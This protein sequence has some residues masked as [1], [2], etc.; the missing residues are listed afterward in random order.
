MIKKTILA[1]VGALLFSSLGVVHPIPTARAIADHPLRLT[2]LCRDSKGRFASCGI[3]DVVPKLR[4]PSISINLGRVIPSVSVGSPVRWGFK[5]PFS[6]TPRIR[7]MKFQVYFNPDFDFFDTNAKWV[8]LAAFKAISGQAQVTSQ[9]RAGSQEYRVYG[10]EGGGYA[11]WTSPTTAKKTKG[12]PTT[13]TFEVTPNPVYVD[14]EATFTVRLSDT[15]TTRRVYF[16]T[17]S[18]C[19]GTSPWIAGKGL[20]EG[21]SVLGESS[22]ESDV[23]ESDA[24]SS[25][26]YMTTISKYDFSEWVASKSFPI[27]TWESVKPVT[28]Q[29]SKGL[30]SFAMRSSL[31]DSGRCLAAVA[32]AVGNREM[33]VSSPVSLKVIPQEK[34]TFSLAQSSFDVAH[35][36]TIQISGSVQGGRR[37]LSFYESTSRLGT[38]TS[39][40]DGRFS[41]TISISGDSFSA[42]SYW[43]TVS[44]AE[45]ATFEAGST[46]VAVKVN[47]ATLSGSVGLSTTVISVGQQF[48]LSGTLSPTVAG[49]DV[50]FRAY[51]STDVNYPT[52]WASQSSVWAVNQYTGAP[53]G[54]RGLENYNWQS[55]SFSY[56]VART[57]SSGAFSMTFTTT[58]PRTCV[59]GAYA[60]ESSYYSAWLSDP[61][62]ALVV[63]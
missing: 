27:V 6:Y 40:D 30:L 16:L 3:V 52:G 23:D 47:R 18:S 44:A 15:A 63:Q 46:S 19:S 55:G 32:P 35:G 58:S 10:P 1:G 38:T 41:Q 8:T 43:I 61:T 29:T 24:E 54:S 9:Q 62:A 37:S 45:T 5:V 57:N 48:T 51:C 25:L 60:P 42:G 28:G 59:Y 50:W 12:V 4:V 22:R 20:G 14:N 34:T 2:D 53:T 33:W 56:A 21:W 7:F 36:A 17:S 11:Q 31:F 39:N 49:R 13:G 26:P